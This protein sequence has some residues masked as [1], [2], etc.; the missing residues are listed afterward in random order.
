[1]AKTDVDVDG[2]KEQAIKEALEAA[3]RRHT[4]ELR[5]ALG[6][7]EKHLL[8]EKQKALDRQKKVL[9]TPEKQLVGDTA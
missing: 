3:D 2:Q 6:R 8:A 5:A 7:T 9:S 1:M 4:R